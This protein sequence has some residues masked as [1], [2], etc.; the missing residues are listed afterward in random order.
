MLAG[1][2]GGISWQTKHKDGR[3]GGYFIVTF[4]NP[5]VGNVKCLAEH[6]LK[7]NVNEGDIDEQYDKMFDVMA[8]RKKRCL[9]FQKSPFHLVVVFKDE[10]QSW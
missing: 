1:C 8:E 7:Y 5:A 4:S 3:P 2:T 6:Y 9:I 10:D